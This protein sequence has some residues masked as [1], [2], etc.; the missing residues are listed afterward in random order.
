MLV[1][2]YTRIIPDIKIVKPRTKCP[3]Y[4]KCTHGETFGED[5]TGALFGYT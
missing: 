2:S 1:L 4:I 3:V 5:Y